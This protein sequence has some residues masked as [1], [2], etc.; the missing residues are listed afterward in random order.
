MGWVPELREAGLMASRRRGAE[1]PSP[2]LPA[3]SVARAAP[4]CRGGRDQHGPSKTKPS[5]TNPNKIAWISLVLFV[6]IG[7]Y[8]WVTAIPNKNFLLPFPCP[9]RASL[10]AC[11]I[12]RPPRQY[13][14]AFRFSQ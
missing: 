9:Q 10:G 13:S 5:Q 14:T 12:F 8:Q 1:I 2:R 6:R 11:S 4:P 7:T 3:P